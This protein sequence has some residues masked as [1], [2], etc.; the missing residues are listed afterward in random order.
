MVTGATTPAFFPLDV[1][2]MKIQVAISEL[3]RSECPWLGKRRLTVTHETEVL[4]R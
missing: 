3:R 1:A 2:V 4:V